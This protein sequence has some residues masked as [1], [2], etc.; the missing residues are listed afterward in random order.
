MKRTV[1]ALASLLALGGFAGT[2]QATNLVYN[3]WNYQLVY[4][5]SGESAPVMTIHPPATGQ[6]TFNSPNTPYML[7]CNLE[8]FGGQ[9]A[10]SSA[11]GGSPVYPRVYMA[12]YRPDNSL[13]VSHGYYGDVTFSN[14]PMDL[15]VIQPGASTLA[16]FTLISTIS[17]FKQWLYQPSDFPANTPVRLE[18]TMRAFS[19]SNYT[20]EVLDSDTTNNQINIWLM[21]VCTQ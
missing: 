18:M 14:P 17:P 11:A 12:F 20:Q 8:N 6:F 4:R 15:Q 21:R 7:P 10:Y 16:G 1:N 3:E 13:I 19:D 9:I 2:A 5:V